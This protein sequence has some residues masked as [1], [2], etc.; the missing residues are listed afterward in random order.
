[1]QEHVKLEIALEVVVNKITKI[2]NKISNSQNKLEIE[3]LEGQFEYLMNLKEKAYKGEKEAIDEIL[4]KRG[5][6]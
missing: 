4:N 5:G 3:E 2:L 1:M 6:E